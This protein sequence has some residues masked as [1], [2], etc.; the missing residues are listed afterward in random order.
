M[1]SHSV[2]GDACTIKGSMSVK[3][4]AFYTNNWMMIADLEI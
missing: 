1:L 3:T 2:I 4:S